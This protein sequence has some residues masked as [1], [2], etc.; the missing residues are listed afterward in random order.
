MPNEILTHLEDLPEGGAL[1]F[2]G[3]R[4]VLLPPESLIDFQKSMEAELGPD[5]VGEALFTTAHH[6]G[7]LLAAYFKSELT[8]E[9]EGLV[10]FMV[11]LCGHLGWGR[12]EIISQGISHTLEIDVFHSA[13]AESYG[14]AEFP[15]CHLL[16]GLYA[17]V[18]QAALGSAV[19]A[20]ETRCRA[21]E[22]PGPCSFLITAATEQ[23]GLKLSIGTKENTNQ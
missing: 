4:Y 14:K 23:T 5:R 16:R 10:R 17:G 18:W 7:G 13:F 15:I 12:A 1:L 20:L 9:D 3:S 6:Y 8:L 21:V 19:N 22:G 11:Q 2:G